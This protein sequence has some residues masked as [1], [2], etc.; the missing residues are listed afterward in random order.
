MSDS[1][2]PVHIDTR[3][4]LRVY[5]AAMPTTGALIVLWG[6]LWFGRM[7]SRFGDTG[8]PSTRHRLARDL[9][10]SVKQ[11]LFAIHTSAATA[12]ARFD[13]EPA[14][15]RRA[16]PCLQAPRTQCPGWRRRPWPTS[17]DTRGPATSA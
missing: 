12:Q 13:A 11:Q 4:V 7:I 6:P 2:H 16:R 8:S 15:L 1:I 9:H 10:D 5:A 14:S 3:A 17:R